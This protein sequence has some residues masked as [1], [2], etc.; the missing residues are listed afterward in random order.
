[1]ETFGVIEENNWKSISEYGIPPEHKM[2]VFIAKDVKY[3]NDQ[4]TYNTDPWCG[5]YRN[6]EYVR[7]PH[8]FNPT[9]Y[10]E[11]EKY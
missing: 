1:M 8:K 9:H 3:C 6:G 10:V 7:W 4:L 2:C 11:I 5:W